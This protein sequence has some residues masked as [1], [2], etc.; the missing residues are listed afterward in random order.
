MESAYQ[1]LTGIVIILF[2][3]CIASTVTTF[4]RSFNKSTSFKWY[5]ILS[6]CLAIISIPR[7]ILAAHLMKDYIFVYWV[8]A[9]IFIF[10]AI[11]S[12]TS[13]MDEIKK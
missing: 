6:A 2:A 7:A 11:S 3:G 4:M 12:Y 10:N 8:L 13:Y 5:S 1:I 9:I